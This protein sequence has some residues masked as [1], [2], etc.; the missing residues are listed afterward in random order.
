MAIHEMFFHCRH[1]PDLLI[2]WEVHNLSWGYLLRRARSL[3]INLSN[4]LSRIPQTVRLNLSQQELT[5]HSSEF[6]RVGGRVLVNMWKV[7]R[8]QV[9]VVLRC[10]NVMVCMNESFVKYFGPIRVSN[11]LAKCRIPY[12]DI[13]GTCQ[14]QYTSRYR[15]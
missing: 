1:D 3:Q 11:S 9:S 2:G 5:I 7:M 8:H 4:D 14:R 13:F 6:S 15:I 10:E 12:T